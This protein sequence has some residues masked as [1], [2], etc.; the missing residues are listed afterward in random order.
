MKTI[1]AII[2]LQLSTMSFANEHLFEQYKKEN[3]Q[4]FEELIEFVELINSKDLNANFISRKVDQK[5]VDKLKQELE[6][7][8]LNDFLP[9]LTNVLGSCKQSPCLQK[10]NSYRHLNLEKN[11]NICF[12]HT[13][14]EF[15]LCMEE[16]YECMSAGYEYF[17]KLAYPTCSNYKKRIQDNKF[18]Q[19]GVDWIYR[20]M[21]CL[22]KGLVIECDQNDNCFTK[23]Q[24]S[25]K[26]CD[27]MTEFTLQFHPG[28]YINSGVGICQ[29]PIR[30]QLSIW[31]T[32]QPYLTKREK[33]EAYKVMWHCLTKG[34]K[35][36]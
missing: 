1:I 3:S 29:L 19:I 24:N 20:V 35:K 14:C 2:I 21:V 16:K 5:K 31:K 18:S 9:Q 34:G 33:Q 15:Y 28:C 8:L 10:K 36:I 13:D 25:K 6:S 22:Q 4:K 17:E 32:V 11:A 30:D 7:E 12:P 26:S 23:D 27:Y